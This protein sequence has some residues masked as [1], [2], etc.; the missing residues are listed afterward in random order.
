[1]GR[2]DPISHTTIVSGLAMDFDPA[3]QNVG[4]GLQLDVGTRVPKRNGIPD[5]KENHDGVLLQ[6]RS[7]M[8][9]VQYNIG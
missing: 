9:R 8:V 1:M 3:L 4:D 2:Q 7:E 5:G 6:D